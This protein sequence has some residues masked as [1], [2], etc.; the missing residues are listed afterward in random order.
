MNSINLSITDIVIL[1]CYFALIIW[2][3]LKHGKSKDSDS[4]FLAGRNMKWPIVGLSL[5]AA[6]VSSSTLM[7]HSG[8]G[9]ISG[10]AVF[11]YNIVSILVMVFFG[12]FFLP[13]YIKSKIFTIPEFLERRFDG[14]SRTYF[15]FI[16]IIG[17]VFLDASATLY[18]GALIVKLIFPEADLFTIIVIMALVAGSYTIIGGLASAINADMIQAIILIIGSC[19]LSI[20][21]FN[22]IGGWSEFHDRF[23]EGVWL[24]LTRPLDDP[25]VPWLGM[26]IGIPILGFYFWGNNQV[27]VQRVLSAKSIDHGRKGVLLVGFLYL[28]TLFIFIIPGLIGRGISLFGVENLPTEMITGLDLKENF[29]INTDEVYPRLITRLLPVG[30]IGIILAAM[31]SALTSTL[32][33]TLSS[34]ST[35]FTMDFY[36]KINPKADSKKLVWVGRITAIVM[37]IVA[38]AWAPFIAKFDS[39]VSY[40]Q[41]I[42]SYIAPPIVG[43]FFLGLFW[44]RCNSQGAFMGLMSGLV[45]AAGMMIV[46]YGA[47][48][49]P[50]MHFLIM[51]PIIMILSIAVNIVTSYLSAPPSDEKVK[52]NSWTIDIWREETKALKGVVWYKNF[53]VLSMLLV[54]SCIIMYALYY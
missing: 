54:A 2:W 25:T 12:M 7:G 44:K 31:V 13:F 30:L 26:I 46:K 47:G 50:G 11:N 24:K 35:L 4:Y 23:G 51:A 16:T 45:M 9:F 15:S 36:S 8:E 28:L 53:R 37:L 6:S 17:N 32:S 48:F 49:D 14:R 41:E 43:T 38:I 3:A 52:E 18:T 10:I 34:V 19:I 33:A 1:L 22:E 29:N 42:V 5:F 39:L 40:Y 21:A 20:Y 27:M